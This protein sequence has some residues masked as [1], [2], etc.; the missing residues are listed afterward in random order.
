MANS[1]CTGPRTL[2]QTPNQLASHFDA[3]SVCVVYAENLT[4]KSGNP[5]AVEDLTLAS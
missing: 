1:S 3:S 4:K 2:Q 5:T